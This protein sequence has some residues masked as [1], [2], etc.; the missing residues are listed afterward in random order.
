[1]ND[2]IKEPQPLTLKLAP[3][4][5]LD[6]LRTYLE[7]KPQVVKNIKTALTDYCEHLK[8]QGKVSSCEPP[9]PDNP[10]PKGKFV[11]T[12]RMGLFL[13]YIHLASVK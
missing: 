13:L 8:G 7:K 11:F 9:K 1:M 5:K 2:V 6:V 4:D 3:I 10:F 12:Y